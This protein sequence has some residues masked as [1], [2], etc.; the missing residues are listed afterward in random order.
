MGKP[1]EKRKKASSPV[2]TR[3]AGLPLTNERE[4]G[5]G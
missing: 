5:G 3:G 1:G 2:I 4:L